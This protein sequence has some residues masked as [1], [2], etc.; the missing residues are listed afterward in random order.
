[1]SVD[2][3]P[4]FVPVSRDE[5]TQFK[6]DSRANARPWALGTTV[7]TAVTIAVGAVMAIVAVGVLAFIIPVAFGFFGTG[8]ASSG[9]FVL[10]PLILLVVAGFFAYRFIGHA[11]GR[12][13]S[14]LRRTRFAAAN[15]LEYSTGRTNPDYPGLVFGLG[16]NRQ[17]SDNYQ[18]V[19]GRQ[20]ELGNYRYTTG[21]GDDKKSHNWGY[22]ALRLERKL[23]HMVLDAR[24]NNGLLGTTTLPTSFRR[25]QKLSLEG[26]FDRYFT[27][28]CPREYE[29]DALYVFT[30]DLMALLIDESAAFDVEI[31]D[32][33][34]F[35][36]SVLP[37]E[38]DQ[39]TTVQRMFRIIETV[40]A[41][42][43]RQTDRY[44]DERIGDSTI[45]LV[46]PRGQR[47]KTGTTFA[48]IGIVLVFAWV[49]FSF[50]RAWF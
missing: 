44:A 38:L 34:M 40:G 25:D 36:Y 15:R 41:K 20:F 12:W 29:R 7:A 31:V 4:L 2:Y 6:R 19:T 45:D 18:S 11:G 27:L 5:I 16:Q 8:S 32:D 49:A 22:L 10:A 23:P 50:A 3:S 24:G 14:L 35:V 30:P 48:G 47:L 33:W 46:A 39:P 26:D 9:V 1:V 28:Y 42:T 43:L 17:T 13:E 37:L 21:S